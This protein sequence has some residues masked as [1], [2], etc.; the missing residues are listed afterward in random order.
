MMDAIRL[1]PLMVAILSIGVLLI[2]WLLYSRNRAATSRINLDDFLLGDDQKASK[3]AA[4]MFGSFFFTTWLMLD[5]QL[6]GK[7][8][9]GYLGLYLTAWVGPAVAVIMTR[10]APPTK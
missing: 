5:L 1:Q 2:A 3:A 4:V 6:K 7:M 8:S 9:E 10:Q